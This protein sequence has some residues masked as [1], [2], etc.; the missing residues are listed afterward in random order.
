MKQR[1]RCRRAGSRLGLSVVV[2][3]VLCAVLL[4]AV[5]CAGEPGSSEPGMWKTS[6]DEAEGWNLS[7]DPV[8][9]VTVADGVLKVHVIAPAQ[10]AW[11]TSSSMWQDCRIAVNATQVAGPV[12]NE[13]G[14][15]LHMDDDRSFTAFSVSG[16]GYV[17]AAHYADGIWSILGS[18]WAPNEAIN[19]GA[20]TNHLEVVAQNAQLEFWV[21]DELVLKLDDPDVRSGPIGLYAGAFSEGGVEVT[22]DDLSVSDIP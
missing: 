14:I 11:A 9:D 20:A 18:D 2:G 4:T 7:S 6:F 10:I 17:R 19:V 12:D 3:L 1:T 21:N 16:D 15:L 22:F 13:Y 5:A 8:A